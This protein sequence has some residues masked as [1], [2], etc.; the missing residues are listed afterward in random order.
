[1]PGTRVIMFWLGFKIDLFSCSG[2]ETASASM[3]NSAR[4]PHAKFF[5]LRREYELGRWQLCRFVRF[6]LCSIYHSVTCV[7]NNS[8]KVKH[9]ELQ[10]IWQND[11]LEWK[12][13]CRHIHIFGLNVWFFFPLCAS[14]KVSSIRTPV[15]ASTHGNQPNTFWAQACEFSLRGT[16]F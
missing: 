11:L 10:L 4:S 7:H 16:E 12:N 3:K 13:C 9:Q 6:S 15:E 14:K 8:Q 5:I 1:M 2:N